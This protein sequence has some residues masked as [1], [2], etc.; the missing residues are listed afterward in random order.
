MRN[1]SKRALTFTA[2]ILAA[3]LLIT[4]VGITVI[5]PIAR[6]RKG[7]VSFRVT[8]ENPIEQSI[9]MHV[10]SMQKSESA[11]T[12]TVAPKSTTTHEIYRGHSSDE[13][14][15]LTFLLYGV[16]SLNHRTFSVYIDPK[17]FAS[18][19]YMLNTA[20]MQWSDIARTKPAK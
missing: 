9:K 7:S 15:S 3:S 6:F 18:N 13:L 4:L 16:D 19:T 2:L 1:F 20:N 8:F 17:D 5:S 12:F 10:F 11:S 14:S